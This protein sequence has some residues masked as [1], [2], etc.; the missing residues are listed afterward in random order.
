[1]AATTSVVHAP[2]TK[3]AYQESVITNTEAMDA[4]QTKKRKAVSA[5]NTP[6]T[7]IE[8]TA[9]LSGPPEVNPPTSLW[10]GVHPANE[11]QSESLDKIIKKAK[12]EGSESGPAQAHFASLSPAPPPPPPP[13]AHSPVSQPSPRHLPSPMPGPSGIN[14]GMS[15]IRSP[16]PPHGG[17]E[18]EG[19]VSLLVSVPL[20]SVGHGL[21]LSAHAQVSAASDMTGLSP[22]IFH[23]PQKQ[24]AMDPGMPGHGPHSVP[25]RSAWGGL[26]VTYEMQQDPNKPG[27]SGVQNTSKDMNLA[28]IPMPPTTIRTKKRAAMATSVVSMATPPPPSPL[29]TAPQSLANVRRP[30]QPT[31]PPIYQ[32][33]IKDS[34]PSSPSSDRPLKPKMENKVGVSCT[35]PHMLGNEL[36]P[37]SGAAAR[38]Q[39]QLSAE[40]AAHA[41][42]SGGA[43]PLVPPPLINKATPGT[44]SRG[45]SSGA[46]SLDQ[47]LERQWEQ[48]S[49]FLMEQAQHFDIASLLSCLHQL[50]TENVRLEDHVGNLLQRRDHLLAVNARLA[51]P[52]NT[53]T[54]GPPEP[55]RCPREN[56]A[57]GRAP[58][59][60][61]RAP[62]TITSDRPH[63]LMMREVQQKPS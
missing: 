63:Q 58:N 20:P 47:L 36:N 30:P 18:R 56:G 10:E 37:E 26:N 49:Q 33:T 38:L 28:G 35:A 25:G 29:Q 45:N 41:A 44:G 60:P 3:H 32:E 16:Q 46:Q 8:Y 57:Q 50:R 51:I 55:T 34:P 17:K 2:S 21:N 1:T 59:A 53:V 43:D 7:Q 5:A 13:P 61:P 14:P 6:T 19:P 24:A 48:G 12:T 27:V 52:L 40:L 9:P 62:E 4:K 23:Q 15:N 31:P 39:E 22:H 11:T 42:G 54:T